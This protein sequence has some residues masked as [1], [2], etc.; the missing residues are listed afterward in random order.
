VTIF[1][2]FYEDLYFDGGFGRTGVV[3]TLVQSVTTDGANSSTTVTGTLPGAPTAGNML[4]AIVFVDKNAGGFNAVTGFTEEVDLSSSSVSMAVYVKLVAAGTETSCT[5]TWTTT[6]PSGGA[7][8]YAEYAGTGSG[9]FE[10]VTKATNPT[11]EANV[12]SVASGTTPV[13]TDVAALA[14]AAF[15]K[16]TFSTGNTM[17]YSNG[18]A[19]VGIANV[20]A[21]VGRWVA[22]KTLAPADTA[23]TTATH[24]GS[25]D[26][27][28]GA[29]IVISKVSDSALGTVAGTV[30]WSG[31]ATGA[32]Q[33]RGA[34]T[35][36]VTKAG[37][38]TG[39]RVSRGASTGA[40]AWV[41]VASGTS[42]QPVTGLMVTV[43]NSTELSLDWDNFTGAWAYDIERDGLVVHRALV[44]NWNDTGLTPATAYCY[45]VRAVS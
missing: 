33:H 30:G 45:R 39:T 8:W 9:D 32:V 43:V 4:V 10:V 29:V 26:Q 40:V 6:S 27:F 35:G 44:S 1:D 17:A 36:A 12:T 22:T 20:N 15:A 18:F 5:V 37:A 34:A 2:D 42:V 38:A 24:T 25:A 3:P 23:G 41:G 7:I 19:N 11:A 31:S 13:A 14:I 28:Q 16:D 21:E